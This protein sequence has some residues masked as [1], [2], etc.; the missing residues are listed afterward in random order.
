[1][2]KTAFH[3]VEKWGIIIFLKNNMFGILKK[4]TA[5]SLFF[6]A[7]FIGKDEYN[8][9]YYESKHRQD[10]F[11]RKKR[12]CIYNGIVEASKVPSHWHSWLHY[13]TE[14]PIAHKKLFWFKVHTPDLTGTPYAFSPNK[15][16]QFNVHGK[17]F[18]NKNKDYTPW[19]GQKAT[20][21]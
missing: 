5:M 9:K 19:N 10:S 11:G 3:L 4:I 21:E 7:K 16:T 18:I 6:T 13:G 15:H 20:D 14:T 17:Y 8:N 1:M 12:F 2:A